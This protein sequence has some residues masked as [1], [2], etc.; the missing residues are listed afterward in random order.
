MDCE[1]AELTPRA[2]SA[3]KR[4]WMAVARDD[5]QLKRLIYRSLPCHH[6]RRLVIRHRRRMAGHRASPTLAQ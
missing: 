6:A 2:D 5:K 1:I 4:L 3:E